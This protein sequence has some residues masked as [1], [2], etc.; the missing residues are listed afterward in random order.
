MMKPKKLYMVSKNELNML[1]PQVVRAA[2]AES[3]AR[4]WF[5][6]EKARLGEHFRWDVLSVRVELLNP[7]PKG[8]VLTPSAVVELRVSDTEAKE[9]ENY[10]SPKPQTAGA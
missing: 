4:L 2:N 5:D 10:R 7:M 8:G 9:N 3:A 6:F 1:S